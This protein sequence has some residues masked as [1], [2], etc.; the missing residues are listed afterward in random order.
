MHPS[1]DAMSL[2]PET[3]NRFTAEAVASHPFF[4]R[5]LELGRDRLG[6]PEPERPASL[7]DSLLPTLAPSSRTPLTEIN[8]PPLPRIFLALRRTAED[9]MSTMAD[10]A[11]IVSTDPSLTTYVLR[12]AN[13]ALYAQGQAVETVDRAVGVIGLSEIQTMALGAALGRVFR[14]PPRPDL[15]SMPHFWRHAVSVGLLSGALAERGRTPGRDRYFVAGLVHDMGRLL[16]AV[17]EPDLAALALGR[18]G[19]AGVSLDA[20]ERTA[21]GFDH[22]VLGGRVCG[23][24]QLPDS[25]GEAVAWHHDPSLCPDNALTGVVHAADFMANLLGIRA[26]PT[27]ALPQCDAGALAA[28]DLGEADAEPLLETLETG[29]ENLTTLFTA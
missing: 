12:L 23:K 22:A 16:L 17:A 10:V 27:G 26:H 7:R 4:R 15:L 20:A 14:D 13:S 3:P 29:L 9:P 5:L 11:R 21:L 25:L 8:P 18:A 1:D 24:W 2:S 6:R 28:L 19:Q